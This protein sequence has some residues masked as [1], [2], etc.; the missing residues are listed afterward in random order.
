MKKLMILAVF[1]LSSVA[2]AEP[3]KEKE[4][5]VSEVKAFVK[6]VSQ[7]EWNSVKAQ[8]MAEMLE[9]V[10][11][12]RNTGGEVK[13]AAKTALVTTKD[14]LVEQ[15]PL[16]VQEIVKYGLVYNSLWCLAGLAIIIF[17]IYWNVMAK[18]ISWKNV[19]DADHPGLLILKIRGTFIAILGI[20]IFFNHIQTL[21]YIY[22][23][24]RLY[25]IEQITNM[26]QAVRSAK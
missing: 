2:F 16:V 6:D 22:F 1:L 4:T 9:W 11:A 20:I 7:E 10:K 15:V 23:C 14:F 25:V 24:P 18:K 19:F 13:D 3:A 12:A 26:I 17:G 21:G 5:E 8:T